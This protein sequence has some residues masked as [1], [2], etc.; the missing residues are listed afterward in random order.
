[1]K[2]TRTFSGPKES[3]I[4]IRSQSINQPQKANIYH[5]IDYAHFRSFCHGIESGSEGWTLNKRYKEAKRLFAIDEVDSWNYNRMEKNGP[6]DCVAFKDFLYQLLGDRA[7]QF[8]AL[9]LDWMQT[10]KASNEWDDIFLWRFYTFE[11]QIRD[12]ANDPAKMDVMLF[13]AWLDELMQQK[14]SKQ[15]SMP[16]T[17]HDLVVFATT[18]WPNLDCEPKPSL[19]MRTHPT[20][21]TSAQP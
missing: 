14:T 6:E 18:L 10:K 7:H 12:E 20:P 9:L 15:S 4:S 19:P 13:F 17:K 8:H 3:S 21:S 5:S 1:M 11:T 16:E 2:H